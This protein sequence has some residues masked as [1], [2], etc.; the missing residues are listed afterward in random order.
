MTAAVTTNFE[1][2][3]PFARAVLEHNPGR[4][5][6]ALWAPAER[7]A[8]L[9]AVYALDAELSRQMA[10]AAEPALVEIRLRWWA[11]AFET[12]KP[13]SLRGV[14]LLDTLARM[15]RERPGLARMLLEVCEA[16]E[17]DIPETPAD[18]EPAPE[19]RDRAGQAAGRPAPASFEA[20]QARARAVGRAAAFWLGAQRDDLLEAAGAADSAWALAVAACQTDSD[21]RSALIEAARTCVVQARRVRPGV[22]RAWRAPFLLATRAALLLRHPDTQGAGASAGPDRGPGARPPVLRLLWATL[23]GLY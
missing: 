21:S 9:F 17:L 14:P 15:D 16:C 20:R 12:L 5:H 3:S 18:P 2:L 8:G 11:E 7:R 22:A 13:G 10:R 4:F 1:A 19:A 23:S 6:A